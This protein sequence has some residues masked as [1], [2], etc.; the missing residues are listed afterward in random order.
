MN[1]IL[2]WDQFNSY[3][4]IG[5]FKYAQVVKVRY[6]GGADV[7]HSIWFGN[8]FKY[9]QIRVLRYRETI[10][11]IR[12][13]DLLCEQ[14]RQKQ[15]LYDEVDGRDGKAGESPDLQK[16][17]YNILTIYISTKRRPVLI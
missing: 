11:D 16:S 4:P 1:L 6:S 10:S 12:K 8:V 3:R 15:Y 2:E 17:G 5:T 13:G 7:Y 14:I 9:H